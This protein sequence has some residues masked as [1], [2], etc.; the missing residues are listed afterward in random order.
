MPDAPSLENDLRD[1]KALNQHYVDAVLASDMDAVMSQWTDDC[2]VL[3]PVGPIVRGRSANVAGVQRGIEQ[4]R[5]F[6]PVEF[7]VDFETI[8]R[9]HR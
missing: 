7:V 9:I 8:G 2:V 5:A 6:E 4:V 1:I 3:P